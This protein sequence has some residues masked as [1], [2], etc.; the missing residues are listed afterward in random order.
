MRSRKCSHLGATLYWQFVVGVKVQHPPNMSASRAER[1]SLAVLCVL[2]GL[3]A[4]GPAMGWVGNGYNLASVNDLPDGSGIRAVLT[5]V[6]AGSYYGNDISFLAVTARYSHE[7]LSDQSLNLN[8]R[9]SFYL[10]FVFACPLNIYSS[11][12]R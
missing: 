9:I 2:L 11:Y 3:I 6:S 12:A 1:V 7:F 10:K 5:P 8:F 4:P